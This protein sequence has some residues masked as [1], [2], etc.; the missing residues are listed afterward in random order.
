M[1][2]FRL[3]SDAFDSSGCRLPYTDHAPTSLTSDTSLTRHVWSHH[4]QAVTSLHC[5]KGGALKARVVTASLDQTC[6]VRSQHF[7]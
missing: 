5:G 7:M 3:L 2:Y 6:K 4:S 1:N